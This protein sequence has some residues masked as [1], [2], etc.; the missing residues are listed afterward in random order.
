M[1]VFTKQEK[2]VLQ[3]RWLMMIAMVLV[4]ELG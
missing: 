4:D 3:Y 2:L 1:F